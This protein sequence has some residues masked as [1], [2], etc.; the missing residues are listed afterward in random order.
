MKIKP[1][2]LL[3]VPLG[4]AL[5]GRAS[6]RLKYC[7]GLGSGSAKLIFSGLAPVQVFRHFILKVWFRLKLKIL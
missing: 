1:A 4:K 3:V 5:S 7:F 6:N 2:S